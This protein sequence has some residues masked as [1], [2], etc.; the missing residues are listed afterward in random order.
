[1]YTVAYKYLSEVHVI[2]HQMNLT[3]L[4]TTSING[5]LLM[6]FISFGYILEKVASYNPGNGNWVV[7]TSTLLWRSNKRSLNGKSGDATNFK[8]SWSF[9]LGI[10]L[11][12]SRVSWTPSWIKSA[13]ATNSLSL[14]PL[15]V[16]A[17]A[18]IRIPPGTRALLSPFY[19]YPQHWF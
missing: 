12:A 1:M 16:M 19:K 4:I 11:F 10:N 18:P 14:K 8:N 6:W 13:V 9:V 5:F 3:K 17:G 7:R 2:Q 15:V